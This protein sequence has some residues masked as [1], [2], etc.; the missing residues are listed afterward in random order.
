MSGKSTY[1]RAV[2]LIQIMAQ[3]GC[4]VP[5]ETAGVPIC[6]ALFTR[7][8]TEDK[9]ESNMGAFSVEVSEMNIILRCAHYVCQ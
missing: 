6:D 3:M 9:P 1:I 2:A 8:S 7:V 4:F 5:A